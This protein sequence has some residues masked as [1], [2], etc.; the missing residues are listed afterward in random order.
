MQQRMHTRTRS[1]SSRR[2]RSD[3]LP[4]AEPRGDAVTLTRPK[5]V[6]PSYSNFLF[7]N[8]DRTG[9]GR[10]HR[11]RARGPR[12]TPP[13]LS[14][15]VFDAHTPGPATRARTHHEG[16]E[17]EDGGRTWKPPT[18]RHT[19]RRTGR[20]HT[21]DSAAARRAS[22]HPTAPKSSHARAHTTHHCFPTACVRALRVKSTCASVRA[23][24]D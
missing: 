20:A 24:R 23:T 14:V 21:H 4:A 10:S 3:G 22:T 6:S 12:L 8:E 18:T 2:Y 19:S 1:L 7:H 15:N 17:V 13:R 5:G 9:Y 16:G 11:S